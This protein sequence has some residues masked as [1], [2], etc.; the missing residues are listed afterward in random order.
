MGVLANPVRVF[1]L[2]DI[3]GRNVRTDM[4]TNEIQQMI[5]FAAKADASSIKTRIFDTTPEGFL[6]STYADNGAY[7]LLPK[8]GDYSEIQNACKNIF[9]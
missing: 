4:G 3:L 8:S 1:S 7:I 2:L 5:S 6:Y 9:N